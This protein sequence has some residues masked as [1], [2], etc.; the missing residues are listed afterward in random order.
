VEGRF[1]PADHELLSTVAR[2]AALGV[3]N[4]RLAV[5]LS[6][7]LDEIRRQA[8]EL[9]A[10]R[11]RIVQAQ[12][13]E[14]RRIERD[15]HDGVQQEIVALMASLRLARNQLRRDPAV[16]DAMLAELQEEA[17]QTLEDIRD[18]AQGIH[19]AVLADR[20]LVEAIESR[21]SRLPIGVAIEADAALRGAR[22][23]EDSEGAAFF[24][25]SEGLANV[26]KHAAASRAS[27]R[28]A[29]AEGRLQVEVSDDGVGFVPAEATGSGL[30]G[31]RDRI[32]AVGGV[33]VVTAGPGEGSSLRAT[34]PAR[35]RERS[36]V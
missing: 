35:T 22:Y 28:L 11:A 29:E 19:P 13:A 15:I 31:L 12:H 1:T 4:G 8:E 5:E 27:V 25:V 23:A 17:R 14:R 32:E 9:A 21:A 34:L 36:G 10:S 6:A 16:A 2:Q 3:H 7:R 26:L 33:L 18:L 20:G 30:T 24:L